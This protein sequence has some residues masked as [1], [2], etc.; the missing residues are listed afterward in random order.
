MAWI[1]RRGSSFGLLE[2]YREGRKV[3]QR[4]LR[5]LTSAEAEALCTKPE[6]TP[7]PEPSPLRTAITPAVIP[8]LQLA[9][10]I[11]AP[12]VPTALPPV[13]T[14]PPRLPASPLTGRE[15]CQM[16]DRRLPLGG[17]L[18]LKCTGALL[19][20]PEAPLCEGC[21]RQMRFGGWQQ[22]FCC[23]GCL[24][25]SSHAQDCSLGHV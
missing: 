6:P 25:G 24:A 23:Q 8:H 2:S 13:D 12:M 9:I 14:T 10:D 4:Y 20:R 11:H 19:Q 18:C 5:T 22:R 1:R 15:R 3:K 17:A 21:Q 7:T 16:C